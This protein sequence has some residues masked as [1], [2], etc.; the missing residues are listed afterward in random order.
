MKS[1]QHG[2][3]DVHVPPTE[4][5]GAERGPKRDKRMRRGVKRQREHGASVYDTPSEEETG[6]DGTSEGLDDES[7]TARGYPYIDI[8]PYGGCEEHARDEG[9]NHKV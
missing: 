1:E 5:N 3:A 4:V 9:F 7:V 2:A 6:E 8:T